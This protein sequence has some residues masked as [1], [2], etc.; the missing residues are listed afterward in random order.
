MA[1]REDMGSWLEGGRR[2]DAPDAAGRLGLPESGPG[3]QARLGRRVVA[4]VV[5]WAVATLIAYL[6]TTPA[7]FAELNSWA[8]LLV[9]ALENVLLVGTVGF[10]IGHR[11]LGMQV[12]VPGAP[13]GMAPGFAR[14][15][16]RTV[17]L[18]LVIPAV[19]WDRDGRGL[20]DR[21]AGTVLVRR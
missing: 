6:V 11:L 18:C 2:D 7:S 19:V 5:D 21:A 10:T 9:F 4:L 15:A 3:S 16:V 1:S 20:H 13:Q 12:R 14:G 8:T 17:L